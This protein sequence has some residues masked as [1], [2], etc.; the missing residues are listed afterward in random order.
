[1]LDAVNHFAGDAA[2]AVLTGDIVRRS[3]T[4]LLTSQ[5]DHAVWLSTERDTVDAVRQA[6]SLMEDR[7]SFP[8]YGAIGNQYART[9]VSTLTAAATRR[10]RIVFRATRRAR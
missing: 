8:V 6:Y 3:F 5:V 4:L 2:M 1:M 10:R 7:F 9:S